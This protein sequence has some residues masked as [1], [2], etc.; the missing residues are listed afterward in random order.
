MLMEQ[1]NTEGA[2]KL[3][4]MLKNKDNLCQDEPESADEYSIEL[5]EG[6]VIVSATDGVL[7]NLFIHEILKIV[8]DY[9]LKYPIFNSIH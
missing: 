8:K 5:L 4:K 7:D 9:K 3:K 2:K 6:D 1:G